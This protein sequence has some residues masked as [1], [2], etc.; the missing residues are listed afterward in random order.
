MTNQ[1]KVTSVDALDALRASLIIFLSKARR[2]LD[3][4]GDQLRRTR[5][6][7]Q[8]DMRTH[9]E[10]E[11]RKCRRV[12]EAAEQELFSAKLSSLRDDVSF[13]QNAV[14]KA[15]HALAHAEE[16]LR[17]VKMWN[18]NYEG[19]ADPMAKRLEGLRQFLDFDLPK[20][21]AFLVQAQRTL[22]EYAESPAP[23]NLPS[24]AP[25]TTEEPPSV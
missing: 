21:I 5:L 14:R 22:E 15:K 16:K 24:V 6:W 23:S 20:G 2:S 11:V 19:V 13:Q 10:N 12:L 3:D 25:A 17:N 18:R 9:W 1:A 4:A 8:H 7:L